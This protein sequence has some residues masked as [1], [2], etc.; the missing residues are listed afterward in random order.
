MKNSKTKLLT[1]ILL[2]NSF[3]VIA[4]QRTVMLDYRRTKCIYTLIDG[5]LSGDYISYYYNGAK[6]SEGKLEN[7]Y[8]TGRWIVWD[9]TGRKRMERIYKNPFEYERIFPA[10]SN[11]GPIPLLTENKF[12]LEYDS[13]GVIKYDLLK[14]ENAIWRHKFWR[15][16]GPANNQILF[17]NDRLY[18]LFKNLA[19]SGQIEL[20]SI[21][22]DRFTTVLKKEE[23]ENTLKN[24]NVEV[25]AFEIKE[26]NIFD[27]GRLSSEYRIIGICPVV[28]INNQSRKL[29][30]IYY[31]D[32]RKYL[33]KEKIT[34]KASVA[35]KT[36]D[37]LF[38][39]RGF[40]STIFKS[41]VDNPYERLIKDYP[42]ITPKGILEEQEILELT[43]IEAENNIWIALTK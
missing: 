28:K 34:Q 41:T 22:D 8:R 40:S 4:Q 29:C 37:D 11:E 6:K 25:I 27:M 3:T 39:L 38:V 9:S 15:N 18:K 7:G 14:A 24:I 26:E 17:A 20:Y 1:L 5:K 43:I 33:G 19:L 2:I 31:P 13:N 16:L 12:K 32:V 23:V 30:W 36:L 21:V 35:I 42:N 10:I